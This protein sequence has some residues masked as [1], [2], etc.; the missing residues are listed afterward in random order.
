[1][2]G[3]SFY[4]TLN[5]PARILLGPG[6]SN[7][8]PRV[9]QAM[10]APVV[11]HLDPEF[12]SIMDDTVELLR[13]VFGTKNRLALP[14][15]GTGSAGMEA[16]FCNLVEPGDKVIVGAA[17]L[18]GD[19]MV[20]VAGRCGAE[21]I[22]VRSEWGRI[23]ELS[24]IEAA[25]K[26]AGKVKLVALVH[27]ET[28]TGAL[29]PLGEIALL[30]KQY[31]ALVLVD[32]VTSLGGIDV[33]VDRL[34]IDFCYSGTQKCLSCTP[35]LAPI[36]VSERGM[37][38]IRNRQRKVQTW[39]LDL[40]L[41]ENYWSEG[42]AYH[43]TAPISMVYALREA[44][45]L[46]LEE[47]L[48]ARYAR[49]WQNGRALQ[50]GLQAMGLALHA[51]DGHQ[52]PMLTTVR[53]PEGVDDAPTR[54]TLL[55]EYNIEIGGGLG[56]LRG[57]IWRIGLMGYSSTR[58]N[59]LLVLTALETVLAEQGFRCPQGAGVSAANKVFKGG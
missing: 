16:A 23:I 57:M 1:M 3:S 31:D 36:T 6:P 43:H 19:R 22:P 46:V 35:G 10:T 41:I 40:S 44:L 38:A 13:S 33:P 48:E 28:S 39:Y 24:A 18:F 58:D 12:T 52:L 59:V 49:H 15:S 4:A 27:A 9:Y 50:A 20:E 11:G 32:A 8:P 5:P 37:E 45:A 51:Q 34:G 47:G 30:A 54:R 42:R 55:N 17:G 7:V 25:L 53:I 14:V 21:V 29:Q 26:Q 56:P 2:A